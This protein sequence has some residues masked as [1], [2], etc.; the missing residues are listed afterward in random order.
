VGAEAGPL[1]FTVADGMSTNVA[2]FRQI[3]LGSPK[4]PEQ[5]VSAVNKLRTNNKAYVRVWRAEPDFQMD[6][7]DLP[8]P[9]PSAALILATSPAA[10]QTRNSKVTELEITA[11]DIVISGSKTVQV[12]VKE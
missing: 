12:D 10:L 7:D 2:E 6:A 9:P 3:A 8:D 4:S 1:Y 5:L 11:G